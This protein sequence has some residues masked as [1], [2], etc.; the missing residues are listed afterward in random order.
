MTYNK[1]KFFNQS[2]DYLLIGNK[3]DQIWDRSH[4]LAVQFVPTSNHN[5][6]FRLLYNQC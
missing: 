1:H 3:K 6:R 5:M 2:L 4:I